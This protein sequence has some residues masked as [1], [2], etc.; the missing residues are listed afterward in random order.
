M[1][2][3]FIDHTLAAV[4]CSIIQTIVLIVFVSYTGKAEAASPV[5][6]TSIA[7][8][9]QWYGLGLV[10]LAALAN[11]ASWLFSLS[12][13]KYGNIAGVVAL[14]SMSI[15][16]CLLLCRF[17]FGELLFMKHIIG[18]ALIALGTIVLSR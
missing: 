17:L 10:I 9:P 16:F 8:Y 3:E 13:L 14:E 18:A 15:V 1:A 4:V 6:I 11:G 5:L 12:A 7:A 2:V